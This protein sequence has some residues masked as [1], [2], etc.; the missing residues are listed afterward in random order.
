MG[1]RNRAYP[2]HTNAGQS[3]VQANEHNRHVLATHGGYARNS[4][5][6][7]L[8]KIIEMMR[9]PVTVAAQFPKI[10]LT[11]QGNQFQEQASLAT[12]KISIFWIFAFV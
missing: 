3:N 4:G 11:R 9:R 10:T 2:G 6:T 7:S 8:R 5:H 1:S 12:L